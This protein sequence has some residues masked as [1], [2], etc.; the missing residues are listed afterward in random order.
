MAVLLVMVR[1][2]CGL[3]TI[4]TVCVSIVVKAGGCPVV[5]AVASAALAFIM[6]EGGG[7]LMAG[8][9]I[10]IASMIKFE[11]VPI[12]DVGMAAD[13]GAFIMLCWCLLNVAAL[14]FSDVLMIVAKFNPILNVCMAQDAF[15]GVVGV[16]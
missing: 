11:D 4:C 14:T 5:G 15:A 12:L 8:F 6:I 7:G 3:V 2:G 1:R 9:A 13:T 16:G 10:R